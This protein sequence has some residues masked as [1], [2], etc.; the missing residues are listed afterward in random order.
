MKST[1]STVILSEISLYIDDQNISVQ[2]APEE[3]DLS[4]AGVHGIEALHLISRGFELKLPT[5]ARR[6]LPLNGREKRPADH[7]APEVEI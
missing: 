3:A 4:M 1:L 2:R 7:E 5:C 6:W